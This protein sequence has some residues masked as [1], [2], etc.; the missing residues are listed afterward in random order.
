MMNKTTVSLL[1]LALVA[2]ASPALAAD[3]PRGV[4]QAPAPA[5]PSTSNTISIE[6]S[7]EFFATA[8]STL[9]VA[10]DAGSLADWYFKGTLSH[11]F[12]SGFSGSVAFQDTLK[13]PGVNN[14]VATLTS[15]SQQY[16][17]VAG[18]YKA[19]LNPNFSVTVT[20][21]LGYTFGQTGYVGGK[22]ASAAADL[23]QSDDAYLYYAIS[24]AADWKVDSHW[25][26][27]V[28]N[29]R[30]RNAFDRTW[31]T[32][33]VTTGVTYAFDSQ[34]SVYANVGYSWKDNGNGAGLLGDKLNVAVGYKYSF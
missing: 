2:A 31:I 20:G 6:T 4:V 25:T 30:Y 9:G 3:L 19:T 32:P 34:N 29:V 16:F 27:N 8:G 23:G 1:A 11:N 28:I 13:N 5:A 12:G 18:A 26:W 33:K 24:G 22:P 17:E 15:P 7:P 10:H 14:A 21:T